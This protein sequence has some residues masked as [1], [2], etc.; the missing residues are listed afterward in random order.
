MT[1][2]TPEELGLL[3]NSTDAR[4]GGVADAVI[5]SND[6]LVCITDVRRKNFRDFIIL[7]AN[8]HHELI[9]TLRECRQE[10]Y[11]G[12]HAYGD[13]DTMNDGSAF[14][15]RKI[16]ALLAQIDKESAGD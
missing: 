5:T 14:L 8:H 11:D 2:P 12:L 3:W 15:Y 7:A 1:A 16:G 4:N 13:P 6:T 10:L 9:E